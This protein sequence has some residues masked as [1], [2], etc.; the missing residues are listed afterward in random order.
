MPLNQCGGL[1]RP[2]SPPGPAPSNTCCWGRD[3]WSCRVASC[4]VVSSRLAP[5]VNGLW[6]GTRRNASTSTSSPVRVTCGASAWPCGRPSPTGGNPTRWATASCSQGLRR[7]RSPASMTDVVVSR[8]WKDRRWC[9]SSRA[10]AAWSG[11]RRARRRRTAWWGSAGRTSRNRPAGWRHAPLA[12][13]I[14]HT[15]KH[16]THTLMET[17]IM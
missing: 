9:A 13:Q 7:P 5:P 12:R 4:R 3:L 14:Q 16:H 8:K 10:A 2:S 6:S 15:I 17:G 1:L 11:R